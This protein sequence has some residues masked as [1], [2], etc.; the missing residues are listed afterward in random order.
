MAEKHSIPELTAERLRE[1]FSYDPETGNFTRLVTSGLRS[2]KGTIA[3]CIDLTGYV[4]YSID[5]GRYHGHRLVWLY[6]HGSWPKDQIDHINGIRHDN[7][8]CNL[9]E[10]TSAQNAQNMPV[11]SDNTSGFVG[12][13]YFS[14]NNN[15][16]A[17]IRV[18][19]KKYHIG[20]FKTA[21]EAHAA[22]VEAKARLHTFQPTIRT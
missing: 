2:K 19:G 17:G 7:R 13:H 15:W 1:L 21:E 12:A 20:V 4:R 11:R 8:L 14:A 22:Y 16:Q 9:R 5:Y 3:G 18:N 6:V 10:C